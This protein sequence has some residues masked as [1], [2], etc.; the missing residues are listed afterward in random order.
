[1]DL[2]VAITEAKERFTKEEERNS[3]R[4]LQLFDETEELRSQKATYSASVVEVVVHS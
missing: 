4:E 3:R 1:M 2:Q